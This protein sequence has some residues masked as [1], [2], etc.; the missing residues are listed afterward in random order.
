VPQADVHIIN[1]AVGVDINETTDN[2]G[3]LAVVDAPPAQNS[4]RIVVNKDGYTT[5]QTYATS[6]TNPN[7]SKTDATVILQQLTQVSFV[8]DK[9]S[10]VN[11]YTINDK[12]AAISG[13]PI[14]MSG[15]KLI[16]SN[17]DVYKLIN[18]LTTDSSGYKNI[19]D[20]EWDTY[21]F[22]TGSGFYLAG[23]NPIFPIS[24]L[25]DSKQNI[26][27][28]MT[29]GS[30]AFLLVAVKDA[31]TGLPIS[32]AEVVLSGGSNNQTLV[33]N[34]GFL[35]QTDWNGGAGQS[36]FVDVKKYFSSSGIETGNPEGELKLESSLGSYISSGVLISSIFDTG[37]S[38]NWSRVDILPSSQPTQ[39]GSDSVKFQIAT[40]SENTATTSW[41]F[42]GPDGTAGSFYTI[43]NNNINSVHDGDRY[44]RYK[45]F[46]STEDSSYTP[47]ISDFAIS[48]SSDCVPPG[49]V[50]FQNLSSGNYDLEISANNFS[51]QNISVSVS[52]NWQKQDVL[53][54]P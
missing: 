9:V 3:L 25:P 54:T 29:D 30:P 24:I 18:N 27:L 51:T 34:Q 26:D 28:V 38:T 19:S 41:N 23:T 22:E 8:I 49:Q 48:F 17:P 12:C 52:A 39:T 32:D 14:V 5:D 42:L 7:P 46:L 10:E 21:S 31:S 45:I 40:A 2:N 11:L 53:L 43:S 6:T 20:L 35:K 33:T 16:G 37:T 15:S 50:L 47:N 44:I 36:D 13:V 4:Y 1:S